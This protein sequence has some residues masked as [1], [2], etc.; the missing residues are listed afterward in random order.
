MRDNDLFNLAALEVLADGSAGKATSFLF[1]AAIA[2]APPLLLWGLLYKVPMHY[3]R[4]NKERIGAAYYRALGL[5]PKTV[6]R[7]KRRC[8]SR[9]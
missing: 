8:E 9:S 7:I 5:S 1:L 3:L 6:E 2:I 4:R